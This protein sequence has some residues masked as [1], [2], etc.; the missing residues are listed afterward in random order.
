ME[1]NDIIEIED[2][3]TEKETTW[4]EDILDQ[5]REITHS[6]MPVSS[7][8]M[9]YPVSACAFLIA[10]LSQITYY[11]GRTGEK[12][13]EASDITKR[14][15]GKIPEAKTIWR[16]EDALRQDLKKLLRKKK[17]FSEEIDLLIA[18][19]DQQK[20]LLAPVDAKRETTVYDVA[21]RILKSKD[22]KRDYA[23][24]NTIFWGENKP[25]RKHKGPFTVTGHED[26]A[27]ILDLYADQLV[28][29]QYYDSNLESGMILLYGP[30]GSGKSYIINEFIKHSE[31]RAVYLTAS[32][33]S[34]GIHSASRAISE[35]FDR[36]EQ[37]GSIVV[38]DEC[39]GVFPTKGE[40]NSGD[41]ERGTFLVSI[42]KA[43]STGVLIIAAMNGRPEDLDP[44]ILNRCVE[45]IYV[46]LPG[47][48]EIISVLTKMLKTK[49]VS[50]DL[51]AASII[52]KLEIRDIS[53]RTINFAFQRA[54]RLMGRYREKQLTQE[55]LLGAFEQ[56]LG[57]PLSSGKEKPPFY[58][59]GR[60]AFSAELA[61]LGDRILRPY[62]YA[63][64]KAKAK[65]GIVLV[66]GPS[67]TGKTYAVEKFLSYMGLKSVMLSPSILGSYVHQGANQIH[68][69]F[70]RASTESAV[71][72]IDDAETLLSKRRS[73]TFQSTSENEETETLLKCVQDYADKGGFIFVVTNI[74]ENIDPALLRPGRLFKKIYVGPLDKEDAAE[75]IRE[76]I[77]NFVSDDV[78]LT[79]EEEEISGI[80]RNLN[81]EGHTVAEVANGFDRAY[82]QAVYEKSDVL[83][84]RALEKAYRE[85]FEF[86]VVTPQKRAIGF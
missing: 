62:A 83:T 52:D 48:E 58:L 42:Q 82:E 29:P 16:I 15:F 31:R 85:I 79:I 24:L 61:Q 21:S 53:L 44:A 10:L 64:G 36:A 25:A 63:A 7:L 18:F 73:G 26:V 30:A 65:G 27:E 32:S 70:D 68:A 80:V 43:I 22:G 8:K 66:H 4:L 56:T 84:S 46:G 67:G 17:E 74:P 6:Y 20:K 12:A 71:V 38:I 77:Q 40:S 59:P 23:Q 72:I 69:L 14:L 41:E 34:S 51:D 2:D 33:F 1:E 3:D 28:H 86:N 54:L 19:S 78:R 35:T 47:R 45:K 55:R 9:S 81:L 49:N 50:P 60:K 57:K 13:G 5:A 76:K 75:I 37:D 11:I 39:D